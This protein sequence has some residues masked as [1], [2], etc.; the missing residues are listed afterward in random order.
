LGK[1]KC[2]KSV[3]FAKHLANV[4]QPDPSENEPED[5]EALIHLLQTPYQ[6]GRTSW[7]NQTT[8]GDCSSFKDLVYKSHSQKPQEALNLLV[9][10]ES[11]RALFHMPLYTFLHNLLNVLVHI[12]VKIGLQKNRCR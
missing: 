3:C 5:E 4:F 12:A 11:Y 2:R 1:K 10:E 8:T 6:L 9:T 7:S